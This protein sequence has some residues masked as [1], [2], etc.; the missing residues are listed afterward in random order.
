VSRTDEALAAAFAELGVSPDGLDPGVVPMLP[1]E[2]WNAR[3]AFG[4]IRRAA[5]ARQC[6]APNLM[7]A[8][9]SRVAAA[10]PH[11][12]QLP[13]TIG[14]PRPLCFFTASIGV[15]G[16]GKTSAA[17]VA[18][19]LI[20]IR[21]ARVADQL[22]LGSGE[23]LAEILFDWVFEKD[24]N[25][26][27]QK[28]KRQTRFGAFMYVDEG[29]LLADLGKGRK[30]ATLLPTI[31]TMW[32]GGTIGN[33]NASHDA[34]RI[35]PAGQYIF[36]IVIGLQPH[37]AG[38]LLDDADVGTPQRFCWADAIDPT[39]P[40]RE[41][42]WPGVLDWQPPSRA[43]LEAIKTS[44]LYVRHRLPVHPDIVTEIRDAGRARA[45]GEI[46]PDPLDAHG[47]LAQYKMGGLLAASTG[48][49]PPGSPST[50]G[51]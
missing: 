35:V 34:R 12:L 37:L 2:F 4:H 9:M 10:I 44:D 14:A 32:T 29:Q 51:T 26:K 20:P 13:P 38:V 41:P 30:G 27:K 16:R 18:S 39:I 21:D 28:V 40:D 15:S 8:T 6:S 5:H 19:E 1:E 17:D 7:L 31:R 43:E 24:E 23:G 45:R 48:T 36:G 25:G 49:P 47:L 11:T 46:T 42:D 3:D 22:P 33:T 50:T